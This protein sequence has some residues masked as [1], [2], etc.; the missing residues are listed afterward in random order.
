LRPNQIIA[1]SLPASPLLEWQRKR[2]VDVCARTLLTSFGLRSL[3]PGDAR[4]IGRYGGDQYRRDSSYHQGT[5]W[6]WLLGQFAIAHYSVYRDRAAASS[7]LEPMMHHLE[8]DGL[9]TLSEVFDGDPP[10]MP[11]GCI[12]QAWTVAGILRAWTFLHHRKA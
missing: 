5:A 6:G 4:Y 11:N 1:V 2:I 10:F 12:A 7:F 8:T 9:G 3:A